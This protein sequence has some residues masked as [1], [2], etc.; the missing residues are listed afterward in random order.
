MDTCYDLKRNEI[1]RQAT[2]DC[3]ALRPVAALYCLPDARCVYR[4]MAGVEVYDEA[5][6]ARTFEGGCPVVAHPPCRTWGGMRQFSRAP[7]GEHALAFHALKCVE[8]NGGV[9]EHPARSCLWHHCCLPFPGATVYESG[10][11]GCS[12]EIDQYDFGHPCRKRTW[13]YVSG[14]ALADLPPLPPK[15]AGEPQ[16]VIAPSEN[17]R[18]AGL[19]RGHYLP[20]S[21]RS[22]TPRAFAEWLVE[23]ARKCA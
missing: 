12:V 20:K 17:Q 19:G 13:V 6:D 10:L 8:S 2:L 22:V 7:E 15:R 3:H 9:L 4:T 21:Q 18:R 11:V 14:L 5:R 16:Y 1:E 23:T